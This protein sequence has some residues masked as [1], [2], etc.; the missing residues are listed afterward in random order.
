[1]LKSYHRR[2]QMDQ[3]S[4][5][6]RAFWLIVACMLLAGS[7]FLGIH[8][9][10]AA[11]RRPAVFPPAPVDF[12]PSVFYNASSLDRV[13]NRHLVKGDFNKDGAIDLA[14]IQW[15]TGRIF[16]LLN[17]GT[18][19][20]LPYTWYSPN[21][22]GLWGLAT[23]DLDNDGNLDLVTANRQYGGMSVYL[24]TGTGTF[25]LLSTRTVGGEP[26]S[27]DLGDFNKDGRLDLVIGDFSANSIKV[28]FGAGNG[29]FGAIQNYLSGAGANEVTIADLNADTHLDLV[30]A[31]QY[32]DTIAIRL[33]SSTGSFGASTT[34]AT[35]DT[36]SS[37]AVG[38]INGDGTMDLAVS[39]SY[40]ATANLFVGN[41]SGTFTLFAT[42]PA[43]SVGTILFE[44]LN[45][46]GA[47]DIIINNGISATEPGTVSV[48]LGNGDGT[49][50]APQSW[51]AGVNPGGQVIADF[52][53][54]GVFDIALTNY[55]NQN[56]QDVSVLL[57]RPMSLPTATST[58]TSTAT[59][60][61]TATIRPTVMPTVSATVTPEGKD[62]AVF[63]PRVVNG[64]PQLLVAINP[65]AIP[66]RPALQAGEVFYTTTVALSAPLP[67]G[68]RV[69]LSSYGGR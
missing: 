27:V 61:A 11:A 24:G 38:D 48:N 30:V 13:G 65:M 60:T 25:T 53:A 20:F 16:I 34:Y 31:N 2:I 22:G 51:G 62:S 23:G 45:F 52:N 43:Q 68:G 36:P 28:L 7:S 8:N 17:A 29:S 66:T 58:A 6:S 57:G 59:A 3:R 21:N 4:L 44:D 55:Y 35:G 64:R 14:G 67:A 26:T 1:M 18:G 37:V 56:G 50:L 33:G 39:N 40:E 5:H 46:D 9:H 47:L 10:T 19:T 12:A 42:I 32:A 15:G 63:L 69:Y 49:F 41:G 54:D